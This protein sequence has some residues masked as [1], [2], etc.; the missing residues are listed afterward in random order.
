MKNI[1]K[2]WI[3]SLLGLAI[4]IIAVLYFFGVIHL[5]ESGFMP[6]AA[7]V[8]IAFLAGLI[9]FIIPETSLEGYLNK[10][11]NKKIDKE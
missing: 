11:I 8:G 2:G 7:E 1:L 5:P 6:K 3:T 4:M 10:L 9:L